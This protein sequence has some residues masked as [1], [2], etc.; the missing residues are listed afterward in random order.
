M[1]LSGLVSG[2]RCSAY[3]F[4]HRNQPSILLPTP[5]RTALAKVCLGCRCV[6]SNAFCLTPL[7]NI[8]REM[9]EA[10]LLF[11]P[12]P[13]L[14]FFKPIPLA[15]SH[16]L[17][18]LACLAFFSIRSQSRQAVYEPTD[19]I[20][21]ALNVICIGNRSL[22]VSS[23]FLH[24]RERQAPR[25]NIYDGTKAVLSSPRDGLPIPVGVL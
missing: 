8:I 11:F 7:L 13:S 9:V 10:P 4:S 21:K 14:L 16:P 17:F 20:E 3:Q 23:C 19:L 2:S 15:N 1:G 25:W 18:L 12:L 22:A 6:R 5:I 24:D